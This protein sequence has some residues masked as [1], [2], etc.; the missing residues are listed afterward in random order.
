VGRSKARAYAYLTTPANQSMTEGAD[1]RLKVLQS[2]DNLGAGFT[3]AS[4]DLDLR[5]GGNLLGEEQSGHIRDVGVELYQ[6]MLEEAVASLQGQTP[7]DNRDWSPAINVGAA[8]LIPDHYVP[9]LDVRMALYRRLS[10]LETKAEREGFA[11]ELIDR[12]GPL[13]EEVESLMQVVAIKGLCKR[14]GVAKLDAGPKGAV[15]TFREHAFADPA[16]LVDLMTRRPLDYKL[17]PDNSIVL[18]GDFP[19]I[20]DR[21]KGVQRLLAPIA[22][23][24]RRARDAA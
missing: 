18:R 8:V 16:A 4:H 17:R 21:L 11:A 15:A 24:A 3:L 22:D 5:G 20:I 2:L 1:K 7:E 10:G 14:A 19:E 9:D 23:A 13:P 12:F 6:A